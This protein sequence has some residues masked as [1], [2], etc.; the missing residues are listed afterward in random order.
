MNEKSPAT[1]LRCEMFS[2]CLFHLH[3]AAHAPYWLAARGMSTLL[4]GWRARESDS[5][6]SLTT[7]FSEGI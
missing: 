3:I 4:P 2:H 5:A 7:T 6:A 1:P